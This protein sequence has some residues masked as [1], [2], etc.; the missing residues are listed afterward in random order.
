MP[1]IFCYAELG[2][3]SIQKMLQK[4]P[5][6]SLPAVVAGQHVTF[7]GKSRKWNGGFSTMEPK[8]GC[9]VFGAAHLITAEELAVISRYYRDHYKEKSISIIIGVTQDK[10]NATTFVYG[11]ED[12]ISSP[13]DDLSKEIIKNLK[14][15][16]GQDNGK[17]PTLE[18]FGI[19]VELSTP[20][21]AKVKK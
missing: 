16:W 9:R 3:E 5:F 20:K 14:F 12:E 10:F 4:A 21:P 8:K 15:F 19:M 6:C 1:W 2:P 17:T 7:R 18:D 11:K 13:S